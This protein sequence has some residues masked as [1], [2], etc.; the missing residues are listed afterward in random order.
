MSSNKKQKTIK[1]THKNLEASKYYS[2]Q[3]NRIMNLKNYLI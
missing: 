3:K 1:K 2:I